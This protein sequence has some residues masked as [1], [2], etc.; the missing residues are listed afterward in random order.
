[1]IVFL[2]A[3]APCWSQ[4]TKQKESVTV[5]A[6][7]TKEEL[8]IADEYDA[9]WQAARQNPN[10]REAIVALRSLLVMI[11]GH[12][13]LEHHRTELLKA[14][15]QADVAAGQAKAAIIVYEQLL[16]ASNEDC[17]PTG[18]YP[19]NCGDAKLG[20]ASAKA[21]D[22]Q[23][24]GALDLAGQAIE[25]FKRQ[26]KIEEAWAA[27]EDIH[28][29]HLMELGYAKLVSSNIHARAKRAA[30]AKEL[31]KE[32]IADLEEVVSHSAEQPGLQTSAQRYLDIA[33]KQQ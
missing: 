8:R 9:K 20:M 16:K 30:E 32:S 33:K 23:W 22:G 28:Y 4:A 3:S 5:S 27:K 24:E 7:Y 14:L 10:L 21:L 26:I 31:L 15:G 12:S 1:M 19:G 25:S 11:D 2:V 17:K 29:V 6:G 18:S 13:F